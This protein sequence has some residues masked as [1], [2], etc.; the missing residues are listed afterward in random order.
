MNRQSPW[1]RRLAL[2]PLPLLAPA[3]VA[4]WVA[5]LHAAAKD[6]VQPGKPPPAA[7]RHVRYG[8]GMPHAT[9]PGLHAYPRPAAI[10]LL[11]E[12]FGGRVKAC[13]PNRVGGQKPALQ[14]NKN[15]K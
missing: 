12:P 4:L 15:G 5:C 2:A 8:A 7:G 6:M 3:I 14:F 11:V 13:H 10:S 1:I 9:R